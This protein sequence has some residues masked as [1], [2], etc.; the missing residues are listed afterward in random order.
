VS[1]R[2]G[3]RLN[4]WQV[5]EL[6]WM[7]VDHSPA[8]GRPVGLRGRVRVRCCDRA[9][10]HPAGPVG[11]RSSLRANSFDPLGQRDFPLLW[12]GQTASMLGDGAFTVPL[13]LATLSGVDGHH[14]GAG[15]RRAAVGASAV[16]NTS[17]QLA[18][19]PGRRRGGS[20]RPRCS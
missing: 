1:R 17:T 9:R 5:A 11:S 18:Q 8:M 19:P 2:R 12:S 4:S 20:L 7:F 16:N 10:A 3:Q 15:G 14:P 13:A 6:Q